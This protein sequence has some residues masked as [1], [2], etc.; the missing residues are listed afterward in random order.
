MS[1]KILWKDCQNN[2]PEEIMVDENQWFFCR[3]YAVKA[4][5]LSTKTWSAYTKRAVNAYADTLKNFD[6]IWNKLINNQLEQGEQIVKLTKY[7]L[8]DEVN[9]YAN[10]RYDIITS[11]NN[12][13]FNYDTA[14]IVFNDSK[15]NTAFYFNPITH[16]LD[17]SKVEIFV[18]PNKYDRE[19]YYI[20]KLEQAKEIEN[21]K[22]RLTRMQSIAKSIVSNTA[23]KK[24]K[25]LS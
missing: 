23:K 22:P 3:Y 10:V 11:V 15:R 4:A 12:R 5:S 13:Y 14:Y 1:H 18:A 9:I 25:Q 8:S 6:D 20:E 2:Q 17:R 7:D 24:I 19:E 16:A 21:S